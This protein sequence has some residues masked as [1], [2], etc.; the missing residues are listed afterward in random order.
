[1]YA[2]SNILLQYILPQIIALSGYV[3]IQSADTKLIWSCSR[4]TASELRFV[5]RGKEW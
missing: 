2:L 4:Y 5:L 3:R 1:M